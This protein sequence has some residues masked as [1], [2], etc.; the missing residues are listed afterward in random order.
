MKGLCHS[1]LTPNVELI[2]DKGHITCQECYGKKY[3]KKSVEN[4]EVSLK[5]LKDKMERK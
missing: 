4:E 5:R 1:C 2:I 3:P